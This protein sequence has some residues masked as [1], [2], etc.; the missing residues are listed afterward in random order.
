MD[1][2]FIGWDIPSYIKGKVNNFS[3]NQFTTP[4]ILKPII[5]LN[6]Y[7]NPF[8]NNITIHIEKTT[9]IKIYNLL[10]QCIYSVKVEPGI[11]DLDL[12]HLKSGLFL[13]NTNQNSFKIL[14]E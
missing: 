7:P 10:G 9:D 3:S 13:L 2:K 5:T 11:H 14:K 6:P 4:D 8:C 1:N 12:N